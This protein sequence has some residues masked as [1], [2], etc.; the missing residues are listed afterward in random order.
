LIPLDDYF[1]WKKSEG[2]FHTVKTDSLGWFRFSVTAASPN[3]YQIVNNNYHQLKADIYIEPGDSLHIVQSSW[4]DVPEFSISG[5]GSEKYNHLEKDY[6]FF[7]KDK[8]FYDKINGDYFPT[9][10]DFKRF[11]DSIHFERMNLLVL[12]LFCWVK[13]SP[14]SKTED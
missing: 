4:A 7:P 3:F 14:F 2:T 1:P 12:F 10:I 5:K 9:E 11:I 8:S 13:V 6:S